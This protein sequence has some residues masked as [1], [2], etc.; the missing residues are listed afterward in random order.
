MNKYQLTD[1]QLH[2]WDAVR[3]FAQDRIAP[4]A[5]Q[6]EANDIFPREIFDEIAAQGYLGAAQ[7]PE[8]GGVGCDAVTLCLILEELSRASGAVGNSFNTH[9]SLVTELI[10]M[11]GT[12]LQKGRF[13]PE[14]I[15]GRKLGAFGLTEPS[16]GSD[17]GSPLTRAVSDGNDWLISGAKAFI[18]N[19]PIADVFVITAKTTDGV[20]AFI[21]ERGMPGF[22]PG[23]ADNKMG[24]H[25]SPTSSLYFDTVRVPQENMLGEQGTGFKK[26]AQALDRGRINVAALI[27]GLAQAS[28]EAAISYARERTQFGRP[29]GA[30]QGI[31]FPLAE[32]A[33]DLEAS[34]L[35]VINGAR[36]Y[37]VG[38]PIKLES[39]MAKYFAA[40]AAL[41]ICDQSISIHGGYGYY[42][43]FPVERY[44]RDVKCYHIA[45]GTSEIQRLVIARETVG[46]YP[47]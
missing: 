3:K 4:F 11:H 24:M 40:E 22:E 6:I 38:L 18:T 16:G 28:Y 17:A 25:G 30:F 29:I 34:R 41:R 13:L 7:S 23:P 32:M 43:D 2:A 26:F 35:L 19:G 47:L 31:Q 33:T 42:C 39:S 46:R 37:D 10:G 1:D 20:S 5:A 9:V 12:A 27:V 21:V 44:Y 36:M 15:S 45:E 8:N 14:L